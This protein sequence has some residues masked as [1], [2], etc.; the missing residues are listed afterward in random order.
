MIKKPAIKKTPPGND[1][2]LFANNVRDQIRS[3]DFA[4]Q[5]VEFILN[6]KILRD[7]F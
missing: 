5:I 3:F 7:I 2:A 4:C 1:G 6:Y